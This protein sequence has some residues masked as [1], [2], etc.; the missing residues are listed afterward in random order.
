MTA[1]LLSTVY[2][3]QRTS[4]MIPL[5]NNFNRATSHHP[6]LVDSSSQRNKAG[7]AVLLAKGLDICYGSRASQ[8]DSVSQPDVSGCCSWHG[9]AQLRMHTDQTL[10]IFDGVAAA[11]G[12]ELCNSLL[13]DAGDTFPCSQHRRLLPLRLSY[14]FS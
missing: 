10:D 11:I 3:L 2:K 5:A 9:L 6:P 8:V 12:A 14:F 1:G 7:E 13:P 4:L